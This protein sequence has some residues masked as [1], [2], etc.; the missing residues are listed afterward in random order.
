MYIK[1]ESLKYLLNCFNFLWSIGNFFPNGY[2]YIN[3]IY[4][5]IYKKNYV[6][7]ISKFES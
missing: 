6:L 1:F 4:K 5:Y 2:E 7:L 3:N